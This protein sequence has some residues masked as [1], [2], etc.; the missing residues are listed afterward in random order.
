MNGAKAHDIV[1]AKERKGLYFKIPVPFG[2]TGAFVAIVEAF[3]IIVLASAND[4]LYEFVT[5]LQSSNEKSPIAVGVISAALFCL[6]MHV[7][8]LYQPSNVLD[9]TRAASAFRIWLIVVASVLALGFFARAS[10]GYSRGAAI[11]FFAS[12]AVTVHH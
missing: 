1:T 12:S 5:R 2:A 9:R 7:R 11:C 4:K 3:T 10:G 6:L 8:R